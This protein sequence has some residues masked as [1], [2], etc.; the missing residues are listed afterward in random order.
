MDA[1]G[2]ILPNV[3]LVLANVQSKQKYEVQSDQ[4]GHF[5]L[6][7]PARRRLS[8]GGALPGF[9]TSQGRVAL[10]SGQT[11]NRDVALQIGAIEETLMVSSKER[12]PLRSGRLAAPGAQPTGGRQVQRVDV[13]RLHQALH[14]E[15]ADAR[16]RYPQAHIDSGTAGTVEVEGRIGTDGFIKELRVIAPADPDFASATV[17]ALRQW[18]FTATRLDGVPVETDIHVHVRFVVD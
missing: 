14:S 18:Q 3:T 10:G 17:E 2:R 15:S 1:V 13:G 9:A 12:P 7:G 11:L 5:A 6:T 16:P 8:A 4:A